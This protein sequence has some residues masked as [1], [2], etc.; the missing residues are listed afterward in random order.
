MKVR[1]WSF[2]CL[3]GKGMVENHQVWT[4]EEGQKSE[5]IPTNVDANL[6]N[7]IGVDQLLEV[8][9]GDKL[10]FLN[11]MQCPSDFGSLPSSYG[12][13]K[14]FDRAVSRCCAIKADLSHADK[15]T[16]M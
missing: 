7:V 6:P 8:L 14:L 13:E 1:S 3:L 16:N 2:L 11:Q 15:L 10:Q 5:C 12:V 9:A 4:V